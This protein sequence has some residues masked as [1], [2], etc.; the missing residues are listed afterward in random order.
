M[1]KTHKPWRESVAEEMIRQIEAGTSPWQK[2]WSPG[3]TPHAP[4]NPTSHKPYRGINALWLDTKGY[5]DPRWL[6]YRQAAALGAQVQSGEK[7]TQIE[8]WKWADR[9]PVLGDDGK[10][11]LDADGKP[12]T[13]SVRLARPKVFYAHV[14]NAEQINGLDPYKAPELAFE[15][16][17]EAEKL[18]T[19]GSVAIHHDQGDR[20]F[21]SVANDEI[22][23]PDRAAFG[24]A[25]EYYA[26]ALHELGHA[27]GHG[28]RLD[29]EFGPFGSEVY[30]REELR[31]EM[32][33][34]LVARELGLGHYPE[35]HAA[36]VDNWL[37]AVREDRNV[38]FR[39][40]RDAEQI[41][42]WIRQPDLRPTLEREA[43]EKRQAA[44]KGASMS[45]E[46]EQTEERQREAA[47]SRYYIA[48]PYKEKDQAKSKGARWD[49]RQKSWYVPEGVERDAFSKWQPE[50]VRE[51]ARARAGK[52]HNPVAEFAGELK[53]AGVAMGRTIPSMDGRWHRAPLEGDKPGEKNAS[54][55][56][57]LDGVPNGQ[58]KNFRTNELTRWVSQGESLTEKQQLSLKAEAALHRA[59]RAAERRAAQKA[60]E[61][62]AREKWDKAI[63]GTTP[64]LERKRV[65]GFDLRK[66]DR[67]NTLVPMCD[68]DGNLRS[69]ET[70]APD[71]TK[72]FEKGGRKTGLMYVIGSDG[73]GGPD[74][75]DGSLHTLPDKTKTV[76]IAESCS[77]AASLYAAVQKPVVV[78]FDAGNLKPVAG[79]IHKKYPDARIVIAADNDHKLEG[80]PGG[81]VGLN[82]ANEAARAVGGAVVAP[83]FDDR[84]K[85]RGLS[86]WNDLACDTSPAVVK[87]QV[88]QQLRQHKARAKPAGRQ[89][90]PAGR[91]QAAAMGA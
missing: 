18:L 47:S 41:A 50:A 57:F 71:G 12:R 79:A 3:E 32:A 5:T 45:P 81:N 63:T 35:R 11:V 31:A 17:E 82:K 34:Y 56:A 51:N 46:R 13:R 87:K 65:D 29:R 75:P 55:R 21:Y 15:P 30:A 61:A 90:K 67:D 66:D 43:Q 7:A 80:R 84:Q 40:A 69:L 76:F 38:L 25:Y 58:I 8:Y 36:Y 53:A 83:Q 44:R 42:T 74:K 91:Q 89:A 86:D 28:S 62:V 73:A 33:S 9:Q 39:A 85:D 20:A 49:R 22:H 60:A 23:L 70:I 2:P 1:S 37:K 48:V 78:A 59:E 10:P 4:H 64:Y 88:T 27:T 26:T 72:R 19:G 54:Y 14:F 68:V 77:T 16:L 6:T 52:E 24:S